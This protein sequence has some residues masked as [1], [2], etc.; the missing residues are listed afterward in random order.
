METERIK[1]A[2]RIR[3]FLPNE[4][5]SK[6]SLNLIPKDDNTIIL[7]K[8][9]EIFQ[10][11]FNQIFSTNSTQKEIFNF[12]KPC[13]INIQKGKNY[14]ILAYGQTGTGKTYTMFG[15]DWSFNEE[16]YNYN[17][18]A[19]KVNDE[20]KKDELLKNNI[21]ID[22]NNEKNGIIPNLIMELYKIFKGNNDGEKNAEN[23]NNI[24]ITCSYIQIYNE[25]IYDLLDLSSEEKT[26]LSNNRIPPLKIRNDKRSGLIIEGANEIRASSYNDIFDILE[27]GEKNRK[28]R[29]T[30]KN[31]M[32][33]RSHTIFMINIEDTISNFKSKIK[34]CDL[35]GSERYNNSDKYEREH[36]YEMKNIN[37]SLF[38]LGNVINALAQKKKYVPYKDSKLT[39]ILEDSLRGNSSIYLIAT[40]SPNEN[41]IDETFHTL[42][43]ADRAHS[44]MIKISPNQLVLNNINN[45]EYDFAYGY[46]KNKEIEKLKEELSGLKNLVY[47]KENKNSFNS[48][49]EQ[50]LSLKKE[51]N[52]LKKSLEKI[53]NI[54]SFHKIIKENNKL[55][56]ELNDL[57]KDYFN[58]RNELLLNKK[59]LSVDNPISHKPMKN[60]LSQGNIFKNNIG[61]IPFYNTKNNKRQLKKI[62]KKK[63][64]INRNDYLELSTG[65]VNKRSKKELIELFKSNKIL[66]KKPKLK[67]ISNKISVINPKLINK[68]EFVIKKELKSNKIILSSLK[69]LQLINN[70]EEKSINQSEDLINKY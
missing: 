14:T 58:L 3:P 53:N 62:E 43:F 49:Q 16:Y 10:A 64:N 69:R 68:K 55:K 21:V 63:I 2:I 56:K 7:Y 50:F 60:S 20:N 17:N 65:N 30:N 40:I 25:K 31:T 67:N 41:N 35:S 47:L 13:L 38:S 23:N 28:I 42:K 15:G 51:N 5:S 29:Q 6:K 4:D 59:L 22:T 26:S 8:G 19:V 11:T 45:N 54:N 24:I 27:T 57:K 9:A 18:S 70:F 61:K 36:I 46:R 52:E 48:I 34:L 1:V 12:I 44:I 33:S 32:S 66:N 39:R 37:K